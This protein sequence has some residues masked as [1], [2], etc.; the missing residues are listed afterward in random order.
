MNVNNNKFIKLIN[1]IEDSLLVVILSS[2]IILAVYQIISRNVFSEGVVWIDPLLRTLVL[3]VGLAGAVVATRTDHHIKIDIFAKYLPNNF[4]PYVH[5]VVYLF[6]FLICLL[7]AWHAARFVFSE[8][9]YGTIAF[10]S[11]P[12]W[13]TAIIIPVSFFLIAIRYACLMVTLNTQRPGSMSDV[14]SES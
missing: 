12:A 14:G 3:W 1:F 4:Q 2:M 6:T 7:I 8:Y 10:A 5:R 13:L 9:E 11:V